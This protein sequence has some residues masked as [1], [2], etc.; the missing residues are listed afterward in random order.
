MIPAICP[1]PDFPAEHCPCSIMSPLVPLSW[2]IAGGELSIMTVEG[3]GEVTMFCIRAELV[4]ADGSIR[5]SECAE[6][7]TAASIP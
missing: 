2:I 3:P 1:C 5:T 4:D 6:P 7:V